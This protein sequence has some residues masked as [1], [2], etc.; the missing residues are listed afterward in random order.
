MTSSHKENC[1]IRAVYLKYYL[2]QMYD[3]IFSF[4]YKLKSYAVGESVVGQF[5]HQ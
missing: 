2:E 3:I 4:L 1:D 5:L